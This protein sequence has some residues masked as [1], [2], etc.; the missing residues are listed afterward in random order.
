MTRSHVYA[1]N[2]Q[3]TRLTCFRCV[4]VQPGREGRRP[5]LVHTGDP[6]A[7]VGVTPQTSQRVAVRRNLDLPLWEVPPAG[8]APQHL[9]QRGEGGE[10]LFE[11]YR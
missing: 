6:G 11:A 10:D 4:K 8:G 2:G 7:V 3:H 5:H 1:G 9:V